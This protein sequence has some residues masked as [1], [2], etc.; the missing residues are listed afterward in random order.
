[1]NYKY[2]GAHQLNLHRNPSCT[3]CA[4]QDLPA[5]R[6]NLLEQHELD[7]GHEATKAL[8]IQ[9]KC[10]KSLGGGQCL[11]PNHSI[12]VS[13]NMGKQWTPSWCCVDVESEDLSHTHTH[14]HRYTLTT[15]GYKTFNSFT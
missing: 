14:T 3:Q 12:S 4:S 5:Q 10:R 2:P 11:K 9:N 8:T 7:D 6:A 1:M 15:Q 13:D